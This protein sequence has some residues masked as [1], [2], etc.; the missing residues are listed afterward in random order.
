MF[1]LD[2][3]AHKYQRGYNCIISYYF[4]FRF[5]IVIVDGPSGLQ[6]D[7]Q[8]ATAWKVGSVQIFGSLFVPVAR[9]KD[10][11]GGNELHAAEF[12]Q[13]FGRLFLYDRQFQLRVF[14]RFAVQIDMVVIESFYPIRMLAVDRHQVHIE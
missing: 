1:R 14:Y 5:R 11:F 13:E 12:A 2:A 7:D 3:I 6:L 9:T 4:Y 8:V 10:I